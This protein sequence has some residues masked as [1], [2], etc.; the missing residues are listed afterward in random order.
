MSDKLA[1][2]VAQNPSSEVFHAL[3]KLLRHRGKKPYASEPLPQVYNAQGQ[4]CKDAAEVRDCWRAH[5]GAMEGGEEVPFPQLPGHLPRKL[6][7]PGT[8]QTISA[9]SQGQPTFSE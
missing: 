6:L 8:H 1:L 9:A 3:H 4:L 5:F 7:Q 2:Q